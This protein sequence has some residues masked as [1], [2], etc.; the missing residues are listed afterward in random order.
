VVGLESEWDENLVSRTLST[1]ADDRWS[2]PDLV[3][4]E[5]TLQASSDDS[6]DKLQSLNTA[7]CFLCSINA[8]AKEVQQFLIRHP[9]ALLLEGVGPIP[10]ESAQIIVKEQMR[11]CECF[12]ASCNQN[13]KDVLQ[14]L[15]RGFAYYQD[16]NF[17]TQPAE[18]AHWNQ[19]QDRLARLESEIRRLRQQELNLRQ[20]VLETAIKVRS[21]QDKL[22]GNPKSGLALLACTTTRNSSHDLEYELGVAS[23]SLSS[24]ER[25]HQAM[26]RDIREGRRTQFSLLKQVFG[27]VRRHVC[28]AKKHDIQKSKKNNEAAAAATVNNERATIII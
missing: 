5:S 19:Y 13:R 1:M 25:E 17:Q 6:L 26:L 23:V 9:Q 27:G 2:V 12:A 8:D 21:Y 20:C 14:I 3:E 11:Q 4:F 16:E 24:L 7:L 28:V 18:H 22:Q 10:E 15:D